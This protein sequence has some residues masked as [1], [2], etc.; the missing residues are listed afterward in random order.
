VDRI[1][2]PSPFAPQ[3]PAAKTVPPTSAAADPSDL[4]LAFGVDEDREALA[5]LSDD[6]VVDEASDHAIQM[7]AEDTEDEFA[8][9]VAES[10]L[11]AADEDLFAAPETPTHL[12]AAS[13]RRVAVRAEDNQLH[14]R[15]HGTG[16]MGRQPPGHPAA[17]SD[18]HT[19]YGGRQWRVR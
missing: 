14:L 17:A 8:I 5:A 3:P 4:D 10:L 12:A 18:P 7:P 11:S 19:R 1:V 2:A 15:L 16:F 6:I 13:P 9:P